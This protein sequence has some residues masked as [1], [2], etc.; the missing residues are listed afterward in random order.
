MRS[1]RRKRSSKATV[2]ALPRPDLRRLALDVTLAVPEVEC[3]VVILTDQRGN[4][5]RMYVQVKD[6]G[7]AS[8]ML[9]KIEDGE[10]GVG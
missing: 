5:Y 7:R 2:R 6:D 4:K 1:R 9:D 10:H 3:E 8:F